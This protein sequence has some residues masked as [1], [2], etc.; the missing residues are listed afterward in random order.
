MLFG[1]VVF[2]VGSGLLTTLQAGSSTGMWVGLQILVGAGFGS[3]LQL[4]IVAIQATLAQD[5][6]GIGNGLFFLSNFGGGSLGVGLAETIFINV[7]E[8]QLA[9]K[10]PGIDSSVITS[11]GATAIAS[12]VPEKVVPVVQAAYDFAIT[13]AFFLPCGAAALGTLCV[14]G[15]RWINLKNP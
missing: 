15:I 10:V 11:A 9:E 1:G 12:V 6:V 14:F 7:L 13:R 2:S 8:A 5:D 3:S 4:A